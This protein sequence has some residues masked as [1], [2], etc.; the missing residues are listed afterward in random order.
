M[1]P[2]ARIHPFMREWATQ[3]VPDI[4]IDEATAR[5]ASSQPIG[6]RTAPPQTNTTLSTKA[7]L[8]S[9]A[10]SLGNEQQVF[11]PIGQL[12]WTTEARR[13]FVAVIEGMFPPDGDG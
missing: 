12:V 9:W 1:Q 11:L 5:W 13:A 7:Q 2:D 8:D 6:S 4:D 3:F 10:K